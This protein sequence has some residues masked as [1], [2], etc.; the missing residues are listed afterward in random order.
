MV[1]A[2]AQGEQV[3]DR[4]LAKVVVDPE[5]LRFGEDLADRV[6]DRARRFQVLADRLLEYDAGFLADQPVGS[7]VAAD[8]AVEVGGGGEII[9]PHLIGPL[10]ELGHEVDPAALAGAVH[11]RVVDVGEEPGEG[12]LGQIGG[13]HEALEGVAGVLAERVRRQIRARGADDPAGLGDLPVPEAVEQGRQKLS[14]GQIAGRAEH[15]AV[16][17]GDG[18]DRGQVRLPVVVR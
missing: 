3:L 7:E 2:K 14:R 15:D 4:L 13:G 11:R 5:D 6:V 9:G 1:L 8:R 17:G 10:V 12:V 16:E 18:D